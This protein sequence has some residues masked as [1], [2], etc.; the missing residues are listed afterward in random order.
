MTSELKYLLIILFSLAVNPDAFCSG[1]P[2]P[3]GEEPVITCMEDYALAGKTDFAD[4]APVFPCHDMLP[5]KDDP[6]LSTS[7]PHTCFLL[8]DDSRKYLSN[9]TGHLL[10]NPAVNKYTPSPDYY[11]YMLEKIVI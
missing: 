4:G 7:G 9:R 2:L 6:D 1:T 3:S 10:K 11:L 8:N 5:V